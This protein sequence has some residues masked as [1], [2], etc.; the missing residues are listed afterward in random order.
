MC[1]VRSGTACCRPCAEVGGIDLAH[2]FVETNY[3]VSEGDL[4]Y[5]M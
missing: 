4:S 1:S 2:S 5:R 3:G